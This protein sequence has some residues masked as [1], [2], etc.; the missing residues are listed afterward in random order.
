MNKAELIQ[1]LTDSRAA[2]HA[3]L[4]ATDTE[5]KIYPSWKIK[6]L[7][8]HLTGW[9]DLVVTTL[10]AYHA[11]QE[12]PQITITS[13]DQFNAE[14]VATRL[15][16][17]YEHSWREWETTRQRLHQILQALPTELFTTEFQYPWGAAGTVTAFVQIFIEHE[18]EHAHDILAVVENK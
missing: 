10:E 1:A 15:P 12:A 3:A 11:N 9:D 2:I 8:D 16:L 18:F 4:K 6:E 14:S 13:I 7:I 5:I 17:S